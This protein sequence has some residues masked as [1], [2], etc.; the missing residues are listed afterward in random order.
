VANE[1]SAHEGSMIQDGEGYM[2]VGSSSK[3]FDLSK[4]MSLMSS[5]VRE[6]YEYGGIL[7]QFW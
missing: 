1:P 5:M 2:M 3:L 6:R 7:A 4:W